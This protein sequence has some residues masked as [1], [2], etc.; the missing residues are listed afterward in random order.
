MSRGQTF[1]CI[2]LVK[3]EVIVSDKS[4]GGNHYFRHLQWTVND[5]RK[6]EKT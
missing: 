6:A 5:V 4:G 2:V 3:S 1:G